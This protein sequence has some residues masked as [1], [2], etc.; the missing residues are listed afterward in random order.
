MQPKCTWNRPIMQHRIWWTRGS[1]Q[2]FS[3]VFPHKL[4]KKGQNSKNL[5]TL[6]CATQM[7]LESAN[8][9]APDMMDSRLSSSVCLCFPPKIVQ[10]CQNSKNLS[11][12]KCATQ[13]YLESANNAAPDMMDSRLSS[14]VC[15]C[16]ASSYTRGLIMM[17]ASKSSRAA[18][19]SPK[20]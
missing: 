20:K 13:M 2:A 5:S 11:T 9:A 6:K 7:Y 15:R 17:E 1:L 16:F 10:K 18:A 3:E 4:L 8:N 12:L 14:S 19:N